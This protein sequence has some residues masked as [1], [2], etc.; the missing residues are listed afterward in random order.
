M[1]DPEIELARLELTPAI[2]IPDHLTGE[3]QSKL[4]YVDELIAAAQ[5]LPSGDR[6]I[7]SLRQPAGSLPES[8]RAELEDKVQRVVISMVKGAFKPKIQVLEDHLD[9]PIPFSQDPMSELARRG[10]ISQEA[11]GVYS[12]GPLVTRLIAYFEGCFL[13]LAASFGAQPYRFP[14]LIPARYLERV[15]YFRAFPHSLYI[16]HPPARRPGRYRPLRPASRLR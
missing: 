2:P 6:I 14:T 16:C 11:P 12:M 9:R 8:R 1:P 15:N 3:V 13:E 4:A 10:E 7:L 5:V